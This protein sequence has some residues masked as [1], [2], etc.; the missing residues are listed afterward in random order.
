MDDKWFR[1]RQRELGV[2]AE[3]IAAEMG[4]SRSNVSHILNGHQRMSLEWAQAFATV[5][6]VP[7]ATVLEKAGI[8]DGA[9]AATIQPGFAEGDAAPFVSGPSGRAHVT[10]AE[11]FGQRPGVDI[12]RVT[13]TSMALAGYLPGDHM[14]VDTHQ[15]S[16]VTA[17]DTVL[18][19][20]Y[21]R[22]GT[23]R[24]VLRRWT[25]PVLIAHGYGDE[26][27]AYVVDGDNVLIVGRVT[28]S[29]RICS[30]S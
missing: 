14:L 8:T 25:P 17:G 10:I 20:V 4:R 28:A 3:H 29:W 22:N 18:A 30:N 19:Q 9:T 24:T 21:A 23:A 6:Q 1:A 26:T 7:L 15:A 5:L 11:A 13:G 12:W 16:R 2:T 27:A